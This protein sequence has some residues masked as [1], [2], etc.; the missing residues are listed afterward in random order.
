MVYYRIKVDTT[1]D[2]KETFTPQCKPNFLSAWGGMYVQYNY[3][4]R[5]SIKSVSL[6]I[7]SVLNS[8]R[9]AREV[10]EFR[11]QFIVEHQIK[12]SKTRYIYIK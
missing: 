10:I 8:E 1:D 9:E 3:T 12:A 6:G 7:T 2:G 4:T 11:Q 5:K